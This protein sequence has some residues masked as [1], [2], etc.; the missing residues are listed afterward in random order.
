M[1]KSVKMGHFVVMYIQRYTGTD[2]GYININVFS[3][4]R[5]VAYYSVFS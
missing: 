4:L 1:K 2:I 5:K 3:P